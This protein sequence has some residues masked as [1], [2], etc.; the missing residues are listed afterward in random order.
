MIEALSAD[1]GGLVL[2]EVCAG[3]ARPLV[4]SSRIT[5]PTRDVKGEEPD[6]AELLLHEVRDGHAVFRGAMS[7]VEEDKE[8]T[9]DDDP[10]SEEGEGPVDDAG[11]RSS[12]PL[13]AFRRGAEHAERDGGGA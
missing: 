3:A 11:D 1:V 5:N 6:A 2:L 10:T 13:A 7:E 9:D 8:D 4:L 12:L